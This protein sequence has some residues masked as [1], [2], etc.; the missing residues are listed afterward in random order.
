MIVYYSVCE[1]LNEDLKE[2]CRIVHS[3][4]LMAFFI[5]LMLNEETATFM[6]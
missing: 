1:D 6:L 3:A 5:I 4:L 2:V